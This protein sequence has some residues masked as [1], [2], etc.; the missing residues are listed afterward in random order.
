MKTCYPIKPR[1]RNEVLSRINDWDQPANKP[2]AWAN[3]SHTFDDAIESSASS[4]RFFLYG[5]GI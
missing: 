4:T 1:Q 5:P 3:Q 2:Q